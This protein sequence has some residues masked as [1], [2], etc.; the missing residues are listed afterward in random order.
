MS[1]HSRRERHWASP[2]QIWT[3]PSL[4]D[5]SRFEQGGTMPDPAGIRPLSLRRRRFL[6]TIAGGL[7]AAPRAVEAQLHAGNARIGILLTSSPPS[8][9]ALRLW[10]SVRAG[11]RQ[12]GYVE[13]RDG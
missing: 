8:H 6:V 5:S 7:L 4:L 2:F 1:L 3:P 10:D 13:G 11:L 12:A 9:V